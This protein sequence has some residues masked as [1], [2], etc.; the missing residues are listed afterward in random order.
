MIIRAQVLNRNLSNVM[1][2]HVTREVLR[3]AES[4]SF[5][6]WF[7]AEFFVP[8]DVSVLELMHRFL[9]VDS[10]VPGRSSLTLVNGWTDS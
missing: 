4:C 5:W 2:L 10:D 3:K 9:T 8:C 1:R 6:P 7:L